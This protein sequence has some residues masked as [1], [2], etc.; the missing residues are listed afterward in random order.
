[1]SILKSVKNLISQLTSAT[2][3][4]A[5]S[6][7]KAPLKPS[8]DKVGLKEEEGYYIWK[9]GENY[10]LSK[11][12]STKEFECHCNFPDCS[13]QR[14]SKTLITRLDQIRIDVKQPLIVTSAYRCTK[15]QA[16]LRAA[17]VNSVVAQK[18][19]HEIGNAADIVPKD[20]KMEG[21]EAVCAKQFDSIGIAKNFLHVDLRQG[22]RRWNY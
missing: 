15:H 7:K 1:M 8:E 11:Y 3:E 12:F 22:K 16:F 13:K 21:F 19:Q 2:S 10:P 17:G 20:Q 9:K 14:I 5:G 6:S 4:S 18:S